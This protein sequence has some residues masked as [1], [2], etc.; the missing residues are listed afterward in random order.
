M[1]VDPQYHE[2]WEPPPG[3]R[4]IRLDAFQDQDPECSEEVGEKMWPRQHV[5]HTGGDTQCYY[6]QYGK[7]MVG[8]PA[9]LIINNDPRHSDKQGGQQHHT[10]E[11]KKII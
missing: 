11:A 3:A 1:Q 2:N 6:E 7:E 9:R 10:A 5:D 4:S 8:S